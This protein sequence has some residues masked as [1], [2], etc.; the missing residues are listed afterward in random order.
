MQWNLSIQRELVHDLIVFLGYVG[1]RGAHLPYQ[2]SDANM[3]L[4][5]LIPQGYVWPT[6]EGSGTRINPNIG[7]VQGLFW[8]SDSIYHA[9]Q[10]QVTRRLHRSLQ[11]GGSYTWA[12]S[13]DTGSSSSAAGVFGNST[14]R[15]FFDPKQGRGL[16]DFDVRQNLTVNYTWQIPGPKSSS[17]IVRAATNGW[18]WGGIYRVSGGVPFTPLVGGDP[19]GMEN[20]TPF[21]FPD[22]L[23]E[24][25]C[26]GSLVNPGNATHYIKTQC[27]AFP[28]PATRMG[29]AGRNI[30]IGP[31]LSNFDM[32]LF[33]NIRASERFKA[34]FRAEFFNIFNHAN[35]APP[36]SENAALF[37]VSGNPVTSAGL[38][39][40]T[41][42][43]ARQI[44][45]GLKLLW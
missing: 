1:S 26:G 33:K 18:Q 13:V 21:D 19:L 38:I 10:L 36:T 25:G 45:F 24:S 41:V 20:S 34:Q 17:G 40:S 16:S 44:Q 28:T 27:F 6:P 39:T 4:P 15:L 29:N 12:K 5:A 43:T 14:Q 2:T 35:F 31:G 3:V 11:I 37:N 30:L 8:N 23:T 22:R 32:S 7:Q 9:L 42:T